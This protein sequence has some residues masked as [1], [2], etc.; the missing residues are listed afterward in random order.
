MALAKSS[1][2]MRRRLALYVA[3]YNFCRVHEATKTTP[4]MALGLSDH[5]WSIGE[6]LD[7][8]LGYEPSKPP[9][10]GRFKLIQGGKKD[11]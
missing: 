5:P 8:A 3:H 1:K 4:A 11:D 7:S 6:L 2:T 9:V 10:Q